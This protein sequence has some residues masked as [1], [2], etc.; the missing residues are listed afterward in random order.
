MNKK[1]IFS[2][3]TLLGLCLTNFIF[4]NTA[5]AQMSPETQ[6]L[7]DDTNNLIQET[8]D[9]VESVEQQRQQEM[10]A[11]SAAC[12]SGNNQACLEYQRRIDAENRA[13]EAQIEVIRNRR[14]CGS[15]VC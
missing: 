13:I 1:V 7:L 4:A 2:F 14:L 8:Y 15:P 11:L 6:Q 5:S 3:T 9:Y 12:N 10:N